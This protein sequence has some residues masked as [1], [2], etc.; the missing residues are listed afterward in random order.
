MSSVEVFKLSLEFLELT[1]DVSLREAA[2]PPDEWKMNG[3]LIN[4]LGY[5]AQFNDNPPDI[6]IRG[7]G[8]CVSKVIKRVSQDS[9]SRK[10]NIA[11][12]RNKI[13][14][15]PYY[16]CIS[17]DNNFIKAMAEFEKLYTQKSPNLPVSEFADFRFMRIVAKHIPSTL[18]MGERIFKL[19][20]PD[21]RNLTQANGYINKLHLS[22]DAG[23]GLSDYS[24]QLQLQSLLK[25]LQNEIE[26]APRKDRYTETQEKRKCLE[27]IALELYTTFDLCSE[28]LLASFS[29][30]LE[31]S[32][33]SKTIREVIKKMRSN[34][35]KF[36]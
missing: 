30:M 33:D 34:S 8:T 23:V 16:L 4:V 27:S 25:N 14:Q 22:F 3:G 9:K 5:S 21:R 28:N 12:Y 15:H 11:T 18:F 13:R 17:S 7:R 29:D 6:E 26:G 36:S 19:N 32:A 2:Y 10:R 31:W 35:A 1:S 24:R 20:H